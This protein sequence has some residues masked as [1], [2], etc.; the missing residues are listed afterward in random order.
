MKRCSGVPA[1][2]Y[3]FRYLCRANAFGG[4]GG[5]FVD[6]S[7]PALNPP[8]SIAN[9]WRATGWTTL[10]S[11]LPR[12]STTSGPRG[13][14]GAWVTRL[15]TDF[16]RWR[17]ELAREYPAFYLAV[18]LFEPHFGESQL[19]AAVADRQAHYEGLFGETG[20]FRAL[21]ARDLPPEYRAV[22]GLRGLTWRRHADIAA[23]LP[24]DFESQGVETKRK[25]HWN[26]TTVDGEPYIAVQVGWVWVGQAHAEEA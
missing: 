6:T 19:V 15:V 7:T 16:H 18:W 14:F 25:P 17:G 9:A 1:G 22:E 10:T 8:S 20:S 24:E 5:T 3:L 26:A 12:G 4:Y 2:P 21:P 13:I 23:F 11:G